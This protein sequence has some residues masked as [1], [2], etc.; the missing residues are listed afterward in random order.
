VDDSRGR[1]RRQSME[2][3]QSCI[4]NDRICHRAVLGP[5]IARTWIDEPLEIR[6]NLPTS[7]NDDDCAHHWSSAVVR[8]PTI[9]PWIAGRIGSRYQK[10]CLYCA[11][12][13]AF[14]FFKTLFMSVYHGSKTNE[15]LKAPGF[16]RP[17]RKQSSRKGE[18]RIRREQTSWDR[19]QHLEEQH[20]A[21]S[22]HGVALRREHERVGGSSNE[23]HEMIPPY[24]PT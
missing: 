2:M 22:Q 8:M 20:V 7:G 10:D 17:S 16:G 13:H 3:D 6:L 21:Q 18:D 1:L 11:V 5:R 19:H 15:S 9:P 4:H 24:S 23:K 14:Q 12:I